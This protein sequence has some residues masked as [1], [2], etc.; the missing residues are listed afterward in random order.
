MMQNERTRDNF[1][2]M[3]TFIILPHKIIN[4]MQFAHDQMHIWNGK[5][6]HRLNRTHTRAYKHLKLLKFNLA[7]A[8]YEKYVHKKNIIFANTFD[9]EKKWNSMRQIND[10][11][12]WI[13]HLWHSV[14]VWQSFVFSKKRPMTK[15]LLGHLLCMQRCRRN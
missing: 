14:D 4:F 8:A 12:I 11:H 10:G 3:N 6:A 5:R 7:I 15:Q 9:R 13:I 2:E 1:I